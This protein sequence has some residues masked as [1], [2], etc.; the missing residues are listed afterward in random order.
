MPTRKKQTGDDAADGGENL[1][2]EEVHA[3][4]EMVLPPALQGEA[5]MVALDERADNAQARNSGPP[6]T[7]GDG[8]RLAGLKGKLWKPGRTLRVRFL[9][10]PPPRVREQIEK[11]AHQW[12]HYANIKFSFGTDPNAEIRI[13]CTP[14]QGSWSYLGTDALTISRSK[15]TMN[16]GW[17]TEQTAESEFSRTTLHE[18]GHALGF[19]HEHMSPAGNIPWNRPAAYRY[20][21]STQGWTKE[22]V[23]S[24]LFGKYA[25]SQTNASAYDPTSIMHYPVPRQLTNGG[26]EVGWNTELSERDKTFTRQLYPA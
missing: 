20:Y 5:E 9:D 3:C 19:I 10:N 13:T 8:A 18:F 2:I 15:P 24:Q 14:G 21:M 22:Q 26:F 25:A 11:Y 7:G 16:Y 12:E 17:F 23:D 6:G 4:T 1:R